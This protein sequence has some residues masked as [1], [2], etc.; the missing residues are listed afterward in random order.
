MRRVV[1]TWIPALPSTIFDG[2]EAPG[3]SLDGEER[4]LMSL[5]H[6]EVLGF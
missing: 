5:D 1:N 3:E 4:S 2:I 6:Q